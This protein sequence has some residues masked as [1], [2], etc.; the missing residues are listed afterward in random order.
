[1]HVDDVRIF[2]LAFDESQ[3]VQLTKRLG[4][5]EQRLSSNEIGAC[6][7]D[8]DSHWPHFLNAFISDAAAEVA[9]S[10][11]QTH[12]EEGTSTGAANTP[13]SAEVKAATASPAERAGFVDRL[14]RWW[15]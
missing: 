14:R 8:L 10:T 1:V 6:L 4:L 5:V 7:V 9:S 13:A 11:P 3:R 15:Q 12:A 2:D